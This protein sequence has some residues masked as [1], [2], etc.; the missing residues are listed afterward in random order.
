MLAR[1]LYIRPPTRWLSWV[2]PMAAAMVLWHGQE[3]SRFAM[4]EWKGHARIPMM[5]HYLREALPR[6]AV[7]ISFFHSGA[8]AHYTGHNVVRLESLAPEAL[9]PLVRDLARNG[10][11]PVF[12]IDEALEESQFRET[13]QGFAVCG[14]GLARSGRIPHHDS[15]SLLHRGRS[16]AL[17]CGRALVDGRAPIVEVPPHETH[18]SYAE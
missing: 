10:C 3:P 11:S 6:D 2:V 17:R 5:G 15:N 8:V 12:V 1:G 7:V 9:D 16:R 14:V 13:F 18:P 4:G